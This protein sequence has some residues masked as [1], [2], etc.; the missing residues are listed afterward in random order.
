L[1]RGGRADG[2]GYPP[3]FQQRGSM[4][5]GGFGLTA[6]KRNPAAPLLALSLFCMSFR[7]EAPEHG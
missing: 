6:E 3:E 7:G 4:L 1:L 5:R 2:N